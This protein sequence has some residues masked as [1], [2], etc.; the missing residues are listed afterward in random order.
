MNRFFFFFSVIDIFGKAGEIYICMG[1]SIATVEGELTFL[2]IEKRKLRCQYIRRK[3][4]LSIMQQ[5]KHNLISVQEFC[6]S[7][8]AFF[9][10]IKS[11]K[12]PDGFN[13]HSKNFDFRR[14]N[15]I[16]LD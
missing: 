12:E 4:P 13:F 1:E 10:S 6:F 11:R 2:W 9:N 8:Q 15:P 7:L 14:K 3:L 16:I 5:N